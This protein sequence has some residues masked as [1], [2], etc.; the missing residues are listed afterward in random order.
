[1]PLR[2]AEIWTRLRQSADAFAG[3]HIPLSVVTSGLI[4]VGFAMPSQWQ[5]VLQSTNPNLELIITG[6]KLSAALEGHG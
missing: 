2:M 3:V 1:M 6:F 4:D 5:E